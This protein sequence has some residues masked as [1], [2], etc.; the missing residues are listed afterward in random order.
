MSSINFIINSKIL[1][2]MKQYLDL[3]KDIIENGHDKEDR[4]GTGT[5]SVFGRSMRFDLS[6]GFPLLTTKRMFLKGVISE[7]LW[8]V[9]GDTNIEFLHDNGVHIWD[10]W[11]DEKGDLGPIYGAQWRNWDNLGIDQLKKLVDDIKN[12]PDSRRLVVSAWNPTQLDEM[13]LPP[14]HMMYQ[15]YVQDGKLSLMMYQRS[16]DMF[17]GVPFNIASYA[18][19]TMMLAQVCGLEAGEYIHVLGDAHIYKN[20][21][22]QVKEQLS[23]EPYPLPK[24]VLNPAVRE[25]DGFT[26]KDF[27]LE[28]YQYHPAIKGK[29]SV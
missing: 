6:Q 5:R 8:F 11:A 20:H 27:T 23:R 4:T 1:F 13:A 22:A 28:G 7:L 14:C 10:E 2:F 26:L 15:C 16:G 21:F 17:L 24:M 29:V 19:L 25:I 12:T 18:L 3:L 9:K